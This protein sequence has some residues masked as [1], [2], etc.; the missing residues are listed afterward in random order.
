VPL[1]RFGLAAAF[2][3]LVA[4]PA[5]PTAES[6]QNAVSVIIKAY[7]SR[8]KDTGKCIRGRATCVLGH[9]MD[10]GGSNDCV[11]SILEGTVP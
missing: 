9:G 7:D 4:S 3:C 2:A 6:Q 10:K 5:L 11:S 8:G 1:A